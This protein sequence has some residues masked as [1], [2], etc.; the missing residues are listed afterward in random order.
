MEIPCTRTRGSAVPASWSACSSP[1]AAPGAPTIIPEE[2]SAEN[3]SVT[4]AWQPP[5]TSCVQGYVLELDD[6]HGGDFR[7]S[8]AR[9][10]RRGEKGGP[11]C[12]V[13]Q[14]ATH[15]CVAGRPAPTFAGALRSRCA[16]RRPT[17]RPAPLA[18]FAPDAI[19]ALG[20]SS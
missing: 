1:P 20:N 13:G 18:P 16:G 8:C 3:N 4:V 19:F 14:P 17:P 6:G 12:E 5:P 7:V 15:A 9:L 11:A 2:C 10:R